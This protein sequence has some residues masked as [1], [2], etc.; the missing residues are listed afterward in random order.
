MGG[1][2]SNI[3]GALIWPTA[4]MS[5]MGIEGAVDVVF[6]RE[7]EAA[8]DPTA[9]REELIQRFYAKSTPL[10]AASG[11]GVDDVIDPAETRARVC[12]MLRVHHG[13]RQKWLPPKRRWISPT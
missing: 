11:F 7:V 2:R 12:A 4:E 9:A 13:R 10:R 8:D 3:D 5:A 6:R 1:S